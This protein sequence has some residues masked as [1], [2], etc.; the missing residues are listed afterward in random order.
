MFFQKGPERGLFGN[1]ILLNGALSHI[2]LLC[3][4]IAYQNIRNMQKYC[5]LYLPPFLSDN[6]K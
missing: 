6:Y 1:P 2:F 3:D 4:A 5:D